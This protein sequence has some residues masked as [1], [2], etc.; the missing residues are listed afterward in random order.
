MKFKSIITPRA[1]DDLVAIRDYIARRNPDNAADFLLKILEGIE[2]IE[3]SPTSF[4]L[5]EESSMVPYDLH[6]FVVRP[7]RIL[8][9]VDGSSIQI[10]HIRHGARRRATRDDLD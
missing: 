4:G 7:Y 1:L 8:Y 6:Q 3:D 2:T 9:R 10:L 5:A